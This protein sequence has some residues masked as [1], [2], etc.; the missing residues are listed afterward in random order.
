MSGKMNMTGKKQ[1]MKGRS[2]ATYFEFTFSNTKR[3]GG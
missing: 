3:M 1:E 2:K